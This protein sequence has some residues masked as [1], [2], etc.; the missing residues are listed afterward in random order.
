MVRSGLKGTN[1]LLYGPPGTGKTELVR[2]LTSELELELFE[3]KYARSDGE[4][5]RSDD[6]FPSA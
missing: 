1:I 4:P 5:M 3:V 6:R 2:T